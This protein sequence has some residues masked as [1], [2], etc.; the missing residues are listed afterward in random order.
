[1]VTLFNEHEVFNTEGR[2]LSRQLSDFIRPLIQQYLDDN[3]KSREIQAILMETL[4]TEICEERVLKRIQERKQKKARD[5][6]V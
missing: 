1:M 5:N 6:N 3:Y 4:L 2:A